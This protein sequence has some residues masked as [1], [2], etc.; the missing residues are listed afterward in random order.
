[1]EYIEEEEIEHEAIAESAEISVESKA[2]AAEE[3]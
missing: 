3:E 2:I 1:M